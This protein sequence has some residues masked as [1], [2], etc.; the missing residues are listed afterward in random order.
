MRGR[1]KVEERG[2]R[3]LEVASVTHGIQFRNVDVGVGVRELDKLVNERDR[4][5]L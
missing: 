5:V 2:N 4:D 3:P 1:A